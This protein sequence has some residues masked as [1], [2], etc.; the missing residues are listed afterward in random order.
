LIRKTEP[1]SSGRV[2]AAGTYECDPVEDE[3]VTCAE[4]SLAHK[5]K[6]QIVSY[7]I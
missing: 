6:I 3:F 7:M 1:R 4:S 2:G 5:I